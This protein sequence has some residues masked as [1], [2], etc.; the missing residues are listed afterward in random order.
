MFAIVE[1]GGKQIKA[2]PG[3][4]IDVEKLP[5]EKGGKV[6]LSSVLLLA[7]GKDKESRIGN[8][9]VNGAVVHGHIVQTQKD[10][11]V[12]VYKMRPKKGT[13]KKQGHRQWLTRVFID[14][15]ELDGKVIAKA[16]E[17]KIEARRK[18]QETE[19]QETEK[20]EIEKQEI[21]H[22]KPKIKKKVT[23]KNEE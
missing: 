16:E 20:Q 4:C 2:I 21:E 13:R 11:K 8:P 17:G 7:N 9:Y 22:K 19:K 23:L 12:I 18:P 10:K 5:Q 6:S 15:I 14:N 3:Q 1:T